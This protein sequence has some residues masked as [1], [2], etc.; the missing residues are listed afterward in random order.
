MPFESLHVLADVTLAQSSL[1]LVPTT[2]KSLKPQEPIKYHRRQPRYYIGKKSK[3]SVEDQNVV[4]DSG[5]PPCEPVTAVLGSTTPSDDIVEAHS[6]DVDMSG[7][8]AEWVTISA[9]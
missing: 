5:M 3:V 9:E 7:V 4:A 2:T 8:S 1:S 6:T